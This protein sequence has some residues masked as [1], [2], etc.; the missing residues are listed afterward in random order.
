MTDP[1]Q[2]HDRADTTSTDD[3]T[4][5]A[6]AQTAIFNAQ[7]AAADAQKAMADAQAAAIRAQYGNTSGTAPTAPTGA[8]DMSKG[9]AKAEGSLL[10][11]LAAQRAAAELAVGIQDYVPDNATRE[12][13]ILTELGQ[14]STGDAIQ[15]DMQL[16]AIKVSLDQ[17]EQQFATAKRAADAI[18]AAP[19]APPKKDSE[20]FAAAVLPA[21]D[22]V[23]GS[24]AKIGSYFQKD[25]AFGDTT[26]SEPSNLTAGAVVAALRRQ[27]PHVRFVIP[28]NLLAVDATPV[29]ALL[30][31]VRQQYLRVAGDAAAAKARA[32]AIR[33]KNPSEAADLD[34]AAAVAVKAMGLFETFHTAL[35]TA[36]ATAPAPIVAVVRGKLIQAHMA[37]NPL[38]LLV[39]DQQLAAYYTK[40]SLW[41][42]F[43]GP[44]LYT[45]G[46]VS[47]VY[48][49]FDPGSGI[50]Q[51][52]GV[53]AKHG[54]Y[55][56]VGAVERMF[57]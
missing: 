17:A 33:A 39:V 51:T 55:R 49:L 38:V 40:K 54:G 52:A 21:I 34:S 48:N 43:G 4:A 42:F 35:G 19:A 5:I 56:S 29:L 30:T 28:S 18:P 9:S 2:N 6:N 7:K 32:D 53:I 25:Y 37:S 45:M 31:P 57:K 16:S 11:S 12:V 27:R 20:R 44:P 50:V 24:A 22:A 41:S 14:L 23:L 47:F 13:I 3:P 46:A 10:V 15:F 1:S 36:T 26:V 8:V